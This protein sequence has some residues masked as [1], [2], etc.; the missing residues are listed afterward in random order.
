MII[1]SKAPLRISFAGGGTDI[2]SFSKKYGGLVLNAT[3]DLNAYCILEKLTEQKVIFESLDYKQK[4]I[5]KASSYL[6]LNGKLDLH[7]AIYNRMIRKYNKGRGINIKITSYSD[8]P[9]GSGLGSSSSFVVAAIKCYEKFL[10][11][12]L[13]KSTLA[14]LA[15]EIERI[16]CKINGGSQDQYAAA[17]GG[18]NYIKFQK[19]KNVIVNSLKLER[20]KINNLESYLLLY[21]TGVSRSSSKI[22]VQQNKRF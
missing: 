8:A 7:K 20:N 1:K 13:S 11:I 16:D 2:L 6:K 15:Y 21:F 9:P 17:F 12:K 19:N 18:F 5:G 14:K 22:I 10:K 4:W 3:I